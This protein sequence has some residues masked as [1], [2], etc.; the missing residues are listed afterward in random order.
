MTAEQ[1][2]KH[3]ELVP[4]PEGG[5]NKEVYRSETKLPGIYWQ[6][7]WKAIGIFRQLFIF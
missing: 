3:L 4:H 5:Y 1:L 2:V 6:R 7:I